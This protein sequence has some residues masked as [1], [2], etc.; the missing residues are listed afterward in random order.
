MIVSILGFMRACMK[1]RIKVI[2][3]LLQQSE[4]IPKMTNIKDANGKNGFML[5]CQWGK[6]E[7]VKYLVNESENLKMSLD[8][9]YSGFKLA[10][11]PTGYK[12]IPIILQNEE[13]LSYISKK[14]EQ[15]VEENEFGE[16]II[17]VKGEETGNRQQIQSLKAL[18]FHSSTPKS[19][20][21]V[22][23]FDEIT[24]QI[25]RGVKCKKMVTRKDNTQKGQDDPEPVVVQRRVN[26][27]KEGI[28]GAVNRKHQH[29]SM[30]IQKNINSS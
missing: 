12:V 30:V 9:V 3:L 22:V 29:L 26:E 16:K 5:A 20:E 28:Y 23:N 25:P 27:L 21:I 4:N 2:K 15:N 24:S 19:Y 14:E 13:Y 17:K 8:D 11:T 18:G 1:G 6:S 10:C 7:V